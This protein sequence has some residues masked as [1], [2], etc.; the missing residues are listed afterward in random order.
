MTDLHRDVPTGVVSGTYDE[1][2]APVVDAFVANFER[3]GEVGASLCVVHEGDTVVDV[4][5]GTADV[6]TAAAWERDTVSV[7]YS[8]TKGA[9]ALCAH[10]LAAAGLLDLEAPVAEVWPE[11]AVRGKERVT[12]A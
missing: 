4:W 9:T 2:F 1:R 11:F 3:R 10:L 8:C 5:G 12:V 6:A 7:V